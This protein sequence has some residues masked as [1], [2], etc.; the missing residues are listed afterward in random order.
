MPGATG[1]TAMQRAT[2]RGS[3]RGPERASAM[4]VRLTGV[5]ARPRCVL[6]TAYSPGNVII[7][8]RA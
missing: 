1:R 5:A 3:K 7:M 8:R 6:G 2:A 4:P